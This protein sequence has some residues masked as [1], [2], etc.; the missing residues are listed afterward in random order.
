VLINTSF[1]VRGEPI[2]ESPLDAL[3]CFFYTKMDV[4]V[5]GDFVLKK[6]ENPNPHGALII[7]KSYELD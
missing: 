1:N 2:V 5:L 4:L 6:E 7:T 3:K